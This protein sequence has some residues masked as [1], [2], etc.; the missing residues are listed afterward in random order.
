M[1]ASA[2]T[3]AAAKTNLRTCPPVCSLATRAV[4]TP[5]FGGVLR[6]CY[7]E[8]ARIVT[9]WS[10]WRL[11][12]VTFDYVGY[13]YEGAAVYPGIFC[14]PGHGAAPLRAVP[15]SRD[16]CRDD[17]PRIS[18]APCRTMPTGRANAR[19]MTGSA[20]PGSRCAAS[21]ER[22]R[23][24]SPRPWQANRAGASSRSC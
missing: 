1:T 16:Q 11:T 23:G 3:D 19:P 4:T 10:P 13:H 17:G 7:G 5:R 18:G 14:Y 9:D 12:A 8:A 2:A 21:G 22:G 24:V 20:S 15:Q 6:Y